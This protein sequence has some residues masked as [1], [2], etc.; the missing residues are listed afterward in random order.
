MSVAVLCCAA[1]GR[2]EER[3]ED[4]AG[5]GP[6]NNS[7][8]TTVYVGNLA[9]QVHTLCVHVCASNARAM[10]LY[11]R[12]ILQSG[13]CYIAA[14]RHPITLLKCVGCSLK[15]QGAEC[16]MRCLLVSG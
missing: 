7:Q 5:D 11:V 15:R 4:S 12:C 3:Q 8:Y 6:E 10:K 13:A 9:H 2:S 16:T 14:N 1:E